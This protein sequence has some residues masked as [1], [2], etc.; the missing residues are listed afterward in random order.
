MN[1][2]EKGGTM[3]H[4]KNFSRL[5]LMISLVFLI[6][7][8]ASI[9]GRTAGQSVDDAR[10][11]AEIN[12]K[13]VREP[14]L[15]A[16]KIDVDSF[17]GNVTLSGSV[18]SNEAEQR[19]VAIARETSGVKSA[20]S[21]LMVIPPREISGTAGRTGTAGAQAGMQQDSRSMQPGT[22]GVIPQ[23][24]PPIREASKLV[25]MNVKNGQGQNLGKI[26]DIVVNS[27][28]GQIAYAILEADTGFLGV[29]DRM[30]AIPW[31]SFTTSAS[32]N[33]LILDIDRERLASAPSFTRGNWPDF[34]DRRWET[35]VYRYY[36]V[37]PYWE[38]Q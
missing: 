21:N 26:N 3:K 24:Y 19:A 10:I 36:G 12:A 22:A 35:D 33:E 23:T 1:L 28:T 18:P 4:L 6:A 17:Q 5:L 2:R 16:M 29:G 38:E 7:S 20:T 27:Y 25:G 32:G 9:T 13:F 8:C 31:R 15:R 37:T 30:F 34:S 14:L 11:N